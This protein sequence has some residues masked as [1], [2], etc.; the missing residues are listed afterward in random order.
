MQQPGERP[1]LT[2][3]MHDVP[4]EERIIKA[5]EIY[6]A[7]HFHNDSCIPHAWAEQTLKEALV[8]I[9]IVGVG[10]MGWV[11]HIT[12]TILTLT[13]QGTCSGAQALCCRESIMVQVAYNYVVLISTNPVSNSVSNRCAMQWMTSPYYLI[14]VDVSQF[15]PD[16]A[17]LWR[18][19]S[20]GVLGMKNGRLALATYWFLLTMGFHRFNFHHASCWE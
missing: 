8:A 2:C 5:S 12:C 20:C 15:V 7:T 17:S 16:V 11:M 9:H 14:I 19:D 3:T 4:E 1:A 10:S 18:D 13:M 6:K